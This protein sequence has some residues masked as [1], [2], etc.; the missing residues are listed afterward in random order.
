M[1]AINMFSK[2]Q[3]LRKLSIIQGSASNKRKLSQYIREAYEHTERKG[4]SQ[5]AW[6]IEETVS[7]L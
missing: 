3:N 7:I 4:N 6:K 5:I 1:S 2:N